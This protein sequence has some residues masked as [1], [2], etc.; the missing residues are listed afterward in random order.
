M[1]ELEVL[2]AHDSA[3]MRAEIRDALDGTVQRVQEVH[4]GQEALRMLLRDHPRLLVVDVGLEGRASFELCD[5]IRDA[6]LRTR[7]LLVASVY[8]NTRYKRRPT[9]LYGADDYVEQ[10]HIHDM[11][12]AKAE[13]LLGKDVPQPMPGPVDPAAAQ[14]IKDAGDAMM[15]IRYTDAAQGERHAARLCELIV[16]DMA[17]YNGDVIAA[18]QSPTEIPEPLQADLEEA[19]HLFEMRVPAE[20]RGERDW[21]GEAFVALVARRRD[22]SR[23]RDGTPP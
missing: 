12:P 2:I 5:D 22:R 8:N 3:Q 19:R 1:T 18:L 6:G 21:V 13:R 15:T 11:L 7:V 4:N 9:S 20:I 16:A 10:H 23:S 14:R 17:L